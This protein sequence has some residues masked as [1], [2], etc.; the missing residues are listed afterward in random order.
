MFHIQMV[1]KMRINV[2]DGF[3]EFVESPDDGDVWIKVGSDFFFENGLK[4][5]VVVNQAKISKADL[6]K[7]IEPFFEKE[8]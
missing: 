4:E 3:V 8:N 5:K 6:K 7:M 1:R 2:K